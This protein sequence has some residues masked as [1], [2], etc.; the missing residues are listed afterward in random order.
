MSAP[1]DRAR[2]LIRT[3][4]H[5]VTTVE[6]VAIRSALGGLRTMRRRWRRSVALTGQRQ[7]AARSRWMSTAKNLFRLTGWN[8]TP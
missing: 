3:F 4:L 5:P 8:T 1:I 2:A 6:R 7:A